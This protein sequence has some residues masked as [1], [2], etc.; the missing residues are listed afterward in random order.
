[1]PLGSHSQRRGMQKIVPIVVGDDTVAYDNRESG[2]HPRWKRYTEKEFHNQDLQLQYLFTKTYEGRVRNTGKRFF[3]SHTRVTVEK[4]GEMTIAHVSN[5]ISYSGKFFH[6]VKTF[7]PHWSPPASSQPNTEWQWRPLNPADSLG[8]AT[9]GRV[10]VISGYIEGAHSDHY[11]KWERLQF[12]KF[13]SLSDYSISLWSS[14]TVR[15]P[16][17]RSRVW[18]EEERCMCRPAR[19]EKSL[20]HYLNL[21]VEMIFFVFRFFKII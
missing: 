16:S 8:P 20:H 19:P 3:I 10:T 13:V 18:S 4:K 9:I 12:S 6:Q 11:P 21:L 7:T 14:M 5:S 15:G 2:L 17:C 1:M